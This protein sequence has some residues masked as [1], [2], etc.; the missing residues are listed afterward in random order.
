MTT[1]SDWP[2][3]TS[4]TNLKKT[5]TPVILR[6]LG[7]EGPRPMSNSRC[8]GLEGSKCFYVYIMASAKR[9]LYIGM[10]N[11][12][13]TRVYQHKFGDIE[14][15]TKRYWV[16]KLVHWESFDD[17]RNAIAREKELKGW[18][19]EKK[20]ALIED[21]NPKWK[22]LAENWYVQS[23]SRIQKK[24]ARMNR[25]VLGETGVKPVD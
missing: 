7:P 11:A 9:V 18:R 20:I 21:T 23:D 19:R 2:A 25:R 24:F 5:Y 12:L 6:G 14:G 15:F 16:K 17:V 13:H 8:S 4:L 10:T 3:G 22:D 1:E